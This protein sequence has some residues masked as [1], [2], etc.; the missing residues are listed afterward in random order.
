MNSISCSKSPYK[1]DLSSMEL[2]IKPTEAC[3]FACTFC[4]STELTESHKKTLDLKQIFLFLDRFPET[5]TIIV[6]GGD[7]LMVSPSYYWDILKYIK[8]KRLKT[9]LS[10]TTNLWGFYKN[11]KLWTKLFR[12]QR[13]G[14]C[15]SFNYGNTRRITKDR[16]FTEDIFWEVSNLFLDKIG[17]RPDFISVITD[18]NEDSAIDN[19]RLAQKMNVEC[20]LNYAMAS[21]RE[22]KPFLLAKIYKI[23][24]KII[25][26]NLTP[27]EFNTKELIK[28]MSQKWT[29][30]PRNRSCDSNIRCLQPDGD[31]YS[32][33]AFGDDKNYPINFKAE[34]QGEKILPLTQR[35]ELSSLKSDCYSCPLFSLCNGCKKTIS[36]LKSNNLVQQHC[37]AMKSMDTELIACGLLK[38]PLPQSQPP[39]YAKH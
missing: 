18:E 13:V 28:S 21:G 23:Y 7:P 38:T 30:C 35:P 16:V 34:I 29:I 15:T 5:S 24:L 6:N 39:I 19:V 25:K 14:V 1:L 11:P 37:D 17:Y 2:I 20:K 26:E 4:S 3:N 32:C 12:H 33:G 22:S 8:E 36:D 27:W 10:F 9:T 31:Y